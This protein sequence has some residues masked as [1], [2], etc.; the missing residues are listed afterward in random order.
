MCTG[1]GPYFGDIGHN[2]GMHMNKNSTVQC[3]VSLRLT[4][5]CQC[6]IISCHHVVSQFFLDCKASDSGK[7][8]VIVSPQHAHGRLKGAQLVQCARSATIWK[9]RR[10]RTQYFVVLRAYLF[11]DTRYFDA[12]S[13]LGEIQSENSTHCARTP[14]APQQ[15]CTILKVQ[16]STPENRHKQGQRPVIAHEFRSRSR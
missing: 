10:T 6:C 13:A 8:N 1:K 14:R 4:S 3:V 2:N 11:F 15:R 5:S 9:S 12:S 16:K 7:Q